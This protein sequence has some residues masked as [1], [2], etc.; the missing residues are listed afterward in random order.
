MINYEEFGAFVKDLKKL[1]KRFSTLDSDFRNLKKYSL[2]AK[3][4]YSLDNQGIFELTGY[5]REGLNFFKVK[6]FS[7]RALKGRGCMTGLRVIYCW[8]EA[9][10]R[11]TFIEM[12]YKAN[13]ACED[14]KR[15]QNFIS[16]LRS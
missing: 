3:H 16:S 8:E 7:C 11:I 12:Y 9:A 4:V 1:G 10:Q 13:Q 5:N 15:I 2:E 6:K 14:R